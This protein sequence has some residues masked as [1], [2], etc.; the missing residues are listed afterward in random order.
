MQMKADERKLMPFVAPCWLRWIAVAAWMGLIFFLSGQSRLPDLSGGWPEIQDI[1]GHFAAYA[2]LALLLRWALSG[3]GVARPGRWAFML[4]LLYGLSDE[5][6]QSFVPGRHP[7]P[8]DVLTDAAGAAA[9]LA[10][11][12]LYARKRS[13]GSREH[14]AAAR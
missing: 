7:D 8:F 5:F 10:C 11:L 13:A 3:A 4:T 14:P 9:A 12:W 6:H 1:G 2:V